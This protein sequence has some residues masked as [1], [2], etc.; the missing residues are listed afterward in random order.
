MAPNRY[1]VMPA[2]EKE[3][4]PV[5]AGCDAVRHDI[6]D[7]LEPEAGLARICGMAEQAVPEL[8]RSEARAGKP[9]KIFCPARRGALPQD[10]KR[11]LWLRSLFAAGV[12]TVGLAA[13]GLH[14]LH[15]WA[16]G[17]FTALAA[18]HVW[19]RRKRI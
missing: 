11:K 2:P 19:T 7:L 4:A 18:H 1:N 8:A 12:T 9:G 13:V 3:P 14:Q 5:Q 16:G 10:A 15:V 6:P 17:A